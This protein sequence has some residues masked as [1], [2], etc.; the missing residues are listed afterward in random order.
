MCMLLFHCIMQMLGG[1]TFCHHKSRDQLRL[2]LLKWSE[3]YEK[4]AKKSQNNKT[5][6]LLSIWCLV[7]LYSDRFK[8]RNSGFVFSRKDLWCYVNKHSLN[9]KVYEKSCCIS[10]G[11]LNIKC[12]SVL[13][14]TKQTT[15]KG[16]CYQV[17]SAM[18]L[19]FSFSFQ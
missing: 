12:V 6:S 17:H 4:W 18:P 1:S 2:S 9:Y 14:K 8:G 19:F 7:F 3:D 11:Q 13:D 15:N 10:K 5:G 16:T